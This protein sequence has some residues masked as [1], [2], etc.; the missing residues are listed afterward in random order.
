MNKDIHVSSEIGVLKKV[1]VHRPDSG[2]SRVSP[3]KAEELLFDDIVHLPVMQEE[4][5]IFTQ[6]LKFFVGNQ[7][8]CEMEDLLL[9]ALAASTEKKEII[10]DRI[11]K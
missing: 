9:E 7:G 5:D 8:V 4:H 1:L 10:I 11:M 3:K 6:V 2:I